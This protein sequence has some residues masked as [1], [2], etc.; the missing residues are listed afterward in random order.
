MA[1]NNV[2]IMKDKII[3]CFNV[4]CCLATSSL[5]VFCI[6]IYC[7]NEDV[8]ETSYKKYNEDD[9]SSYPSVTFCIINPFKE[10]ALKVHGHIIDV[11]SYLSF[12]KGDYWDEKMN[13]VSYEGVTKNWKDYIVDAKT[14]HDFGLKEY[15][16]GNAITPKE[17]VIPSVHGIS[18]CITFDLPIGVKKTIQHVICLLYTSPSPR[19]S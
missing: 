19:D 12:L 1:K 8:T 5:L 18:Q 3:L 13:N 15:D 9:T 6:Y 14:Y 2:V 10:D 16:E 17:D 11:N 4:I 7:K